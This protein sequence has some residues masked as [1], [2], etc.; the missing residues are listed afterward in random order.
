VDQL[1]QARTQD[2]ARA[3]QVGLELVVAGLFLPSLMGEQLVR[4][5]P[6]VEPVGQGFLPDR[7]GADLGGQERMG[8]AL[9]QRHHP[10]F[11]E[12]R[13]VVP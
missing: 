2:L 5:Q 12:R 8:A 1:G 10:R 7:P 13:T 4:A 3:A 11:R 9:G 6:L